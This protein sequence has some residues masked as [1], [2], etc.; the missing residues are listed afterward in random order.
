MTAS[1]IDIASNLKIRISD[2]LD[3]SGCHRV[4]QQATHPEIS[5][6]SF[7]LFGFKVI[8]ISDIENKLIWKN[9]LPNSPFSIRPVAI[10]ALQENEDN[11]RYLMDRLINRESTQ[12]V[13]DGLELTS[14][15][16]QVEIQ[17]SQL[18][19]KMAKILSGA[20]GACCQFCTATFKQIHDLDMVKDG[21]TTNR[22]ITDAKVLFE[23]V[24]EE[25][26]LSLSSNQR[27]NITHKP[28]SD[29]D[30]IPSSPLH[31]YLRCFGWILYLINHLHAGV[32]K[33]SPTSKRVSDAKKFITIL[34]ND[35][36]NIIIDIPSTQG[37]TTTTGNVVRR[38]LIRKDDNDQDFL[39]W[40]LTVIPP[41]FKSHIIEIHTCLGAILRVY[42]SSKRVDTEELALVCSKIY[43]SILCEFPWAN[44]SPTL[45]K[46]LA[47]APEFISTFNDGH[48][49]EHLSEE[50]L[51]ASNKYIRRYRVRL[52]L[53]FSFEENLKD[54]FVRMISHSDPILLMNRKFAIRKPPSCQQLKSNQDILVKNLI[55][56]DDDNIDD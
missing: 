10:L 51:E 36:L 14:G 30:I 56:Q 15:I 42:N 55:H 37:G 21:F 52:T 40:V 32:F 8:S 39:Y 45:H 9:P 18:D 41:E 54:I 2:G 16:C 13:E 4:Y 29:L 43:Q 17:R 31:A 49:L 19:G 34:I 12:I 38:C 11:I 23:E 7:I 33:W 47:H 44:I 24:Y 5:T 48:G 28:I 3:G 20:G 25:E 1:D 35:N 6:K 46:L 26:F 22:S 53:K 50:G 27:F